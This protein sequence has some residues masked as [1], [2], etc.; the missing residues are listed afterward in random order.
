MLNVM[1]VLFVFALCL[2]N[3]L[4]KTSILIKTTH[5]INFVIFVS[6]VSNISMG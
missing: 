5:Q 6:F 4:T 1:L 2:K 3:E